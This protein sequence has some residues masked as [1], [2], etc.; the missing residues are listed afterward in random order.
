MDEKPTCPRG[1]PPVVRLSLVRQ[2]C[3]RV[4]GEKL[5]TPNAIHEYLK[6][7]YGCEAQEWAIVVGVDSH[8]TPL[9]IH[10]VAMGGMTET[11]VDPKIVF[12]G[13]LLMGAVAFI[14]CHNHPSGD[15]TPSA[16]DDALTR[17]LSRGGEML[18]IRLVDHIIVSGRGFYSYAGQ[19]RLP[20]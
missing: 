7:E 12:G 10:E 16:Q 13:L 15:N 18:A 3:P 20:R 6:R 2:K 1:A 19:G 9:G 8:G 5:R 11:T 17:T 4:S 14:F